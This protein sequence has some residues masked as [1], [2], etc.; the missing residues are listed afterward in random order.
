MYSRIIT[1]PKQ[2]SFF[3]FGPRGTGKTSWL[4]TTFPKALYLDLLKDE[5]YT[6]L[7]SYP[8][9]L[10]QWIR[11]DNTNLVIIDEVQKLPK[12]LDEVHR[13]IEKQ[14]CRFILT[15]SSA[16]KLKRS[17]VNLLAGRAL[18][19]Q[20]HPLCINELGGD[21]DLA[22]SLRFGQL[23]QV[24]HHEKPEAFLK[25]YVA[26]YLKE[27][28]HQEGLTR[29]IGAFGRF[30]EAASFS[31]ASVV[32]ISEV[33]REAAIERKTV[34]QYFTIL[35]DLLLAVRIP[36]FSKRA[37]REMTAHPKFFFFDVGVY[38]SIRPRGPL[39]IPAEIDGPAMETLFFQEFRALNDYYDLGYGLSFWRTQSKLEVD[40]IAYGENGLKAFEIKRNS[41]LRDSD[42]AGLVQ[43]HIDYPTSQCYCLY[44]GTIPY[45]SG[46]IQIIPFDQGLQTLR[47]LLEKT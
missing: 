36:V 1:P 34:E 7:A 25:S 5:T 31:Q 15:G 3:L 8:G 22:F 16:R 37:K 17:D 13:L 20:M 23:P 32:N 27:E 2:S 41:K 12:L 30:L 4:R 9:R 47:E 46:P 39:D 26:T 29:N 19:L 45:K 11:D 42:L 28:V 14:K 38:R 10:E 44:G 40:F 35:E 24:R 33:A 6:E 43:F 21:F 18:T